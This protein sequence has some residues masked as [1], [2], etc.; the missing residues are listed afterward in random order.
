LKLE[1]YDN[2]E[3][4]SSTSGRFPFD[5]SATKDGKEYVFQVTMNTSGRKKV[6]HKFAI[7]HILHHKVLY[8]SIETNRYK[9]KDIPNGGCVDL[10]IKDVDNAS[11]FV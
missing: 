10:S 3:H 2:V 6:A 7:R 9:I 5:F 1:G 11:V 4:W 8:I